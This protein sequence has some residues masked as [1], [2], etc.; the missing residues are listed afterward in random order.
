M[1]S[2]TVGGNSNSLVSTHITVTIIIVHKFLLHIVDVVVPIENP[3]SVDMSFLE[4][5]SVIYSSVNHFRLEILLA[6]PSLSVF[7]SIG[8]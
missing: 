2:C 1:I 7:E 5:N 6:F 4:N 3:L 8:L